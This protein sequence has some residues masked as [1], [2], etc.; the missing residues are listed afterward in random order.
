MSSDCAVLR[1]ALVRGECLAAPWGSTGLCRGF[2]PGDRKGLSL[3]GGQALVLLPSDPLSCLSSCRR[4]MAMAN[5]AG[6]SRAPSRRT[7]GGG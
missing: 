3:T 1:E 2:G 6:S 5:C 4:C 7:S